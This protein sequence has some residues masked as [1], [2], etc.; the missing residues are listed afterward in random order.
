M[1]ASK[2]DISRAFIIVFAGM[3]WLY[4][5]VIL[6]LVPTM[7]SILLPTPTSYSV[8]VTLRNTVVAV[9]AMI[10]C[11]SVLSW[12]MKKADRMTKRFGLA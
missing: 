6:V 4:I 3:L 2:K 12:V 9:L 8:A 1:K 11:A 10:G 5:S 7:T